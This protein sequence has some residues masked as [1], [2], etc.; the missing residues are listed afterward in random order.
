MANHL[1]SDLVSYKSKCCDIKLSMSLFAGLPTA[2][3]A[4]GLLYYLTPE[5]VKNLLSTLASISGPGECLHPPLF[6]MTPFTL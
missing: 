4:E 2:Y 1:I 3:L 6:A 5:A